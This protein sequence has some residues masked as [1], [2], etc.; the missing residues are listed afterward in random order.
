M[1]TTVQATSISTI[2]QPIN[3]TLLLIIT[4]LI[5]LLI[6]DPSAIDVVVSAVS[7]AYLAVSTFVAATLLL[8]FSIEKVFKFDLSVVLARSGRWQVLLASAL[9]ALPGCGGAIIV[10]TRYV[11]GNLSFGSLLATLTAT[12]GDAAFLLIAKEPATGILIIAISFIVGALTGFITDLIHGPDFMRPKY[13][14]KSNGVQSSKVLT[15]NRGLSVKLL[16]RFWMF[17]VIP[18]IVMGFALA[19]QY[20][21]DALLGFASVNSPAT[22]WGFLGGTLCFSMWALPRI[23]TQIPTRQGHERGVIGRTISDTNFVTGWVVIAF[24][25]FELTVH[26]ANFDLSS[27]FAPMAA[28][29]PLIAILIGFLPGCGPQMLITTMYLSG[30]IPLSAQI[31][32]AISNDGDALFPAIAMAPKAAIVAT[33]YSA[34]P[35]LIVAYGWYFLVENH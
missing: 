11:S 15:S 19:F 13:E 14:E 22:I 29:T 21:L 33:I 6:V 32:N 8:F 5:I 17:L 20:D 26:F 23:F 4:S 9:G 18:G 1:S 25:M 28:F 10:V 24:L 16:D 34:L 3:K 31:G 12:M 2:N 35:A 7:E 30:F 27:V